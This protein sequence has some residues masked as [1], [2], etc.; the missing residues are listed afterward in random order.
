MAVRVNN[1]KLR[2]S[3]LGCDINRAQQISQTDPDARYMATSGRGSGMVGYNV[4]TAGM[5]SGTCAERHIANRQRIIHLNY[6]AASSA[7]SAHLGR[8]ISLP[9]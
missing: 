8:C 7:G 1:L 2:R 4:Q 9:I 6:A 3:A 5:R